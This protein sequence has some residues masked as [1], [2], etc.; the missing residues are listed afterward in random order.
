MANREIKI[1]Y[2]GMEYRLGFSRATVRSMERNGFNLDKVQDAPVTMIPLLFSGSFLLH[3]KRV[4]EEKINE[5]FNHIEN[6]DDLVSTLAELY[7]EAVSTLMED[8]DEGDSKKATW[9]VA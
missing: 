3:H 1:T 7:I 5:I 2:E 4:K 8:P 9:E 6:K